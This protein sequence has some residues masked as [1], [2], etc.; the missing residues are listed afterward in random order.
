[1]KFERVQA[2]SDSSERENDVYVYVDESRIVSSKYE[3]KSEWCCAREDKY[4]YG[5][6][7]DRCKHIKAHAFSALEEE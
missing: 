1:M 3:Y 2:E 7:V 6:G 4:E 5:C